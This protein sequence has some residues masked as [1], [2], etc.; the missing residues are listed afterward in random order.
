MNQ[1]Q[2]PTEETLGEGVD[3]YDLRA[4]FGTPNS[5]IMIYL[6]LARSAVVQREWVGRSQVATFLL[7]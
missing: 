1:V 5:I 2:K 7:C 6:N 3:T 4:P